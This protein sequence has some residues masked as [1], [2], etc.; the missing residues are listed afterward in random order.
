MSAPNDNN[1]IYFENCNFLRCK[2]VELFERGL[3]IP[4]P[5]ESDDGE[6]L[7]SWK[8]DAALR[9]VM[10]RPAS[11]FATVLLQQLLGSRGRRP[12]AVT[13]G[14]HLRRCSLSQLGPSSE[15]PDYFVVTALARLDSVIA[16]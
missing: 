13:L 10:C 9:H 16:T 1:V 7:Q 15:A 12:A 11:T 2:F 3:A 6:L 5:P 14:S 4:P 8:R